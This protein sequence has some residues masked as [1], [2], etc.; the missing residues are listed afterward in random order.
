[1]VITNYF[2]NNFIWFFDNNDS[3]KCISSFYLYNF[4]KKS[5][6]VLGI[7]AYYHDS[8]V[9]LIENGEIKSAVQEER[10]TR[11][12]HDPSF[13]VNA[14][15]YCI[16]EA[17][18]DINQLDYVCFYEKPF[19]KFERLLETYLSFAPKGFSSFRMAIPIWVREK[20]FQKNLLIKELIKIGANDDI[21]KK[22]FSQSII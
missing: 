18:I 3:G 9:T 17:N 21:K 10:F 2:S 5:M 12:K 8:A 1:M 15:R 7:S 14:L 13:P 11:I 22:Y 6:R 20:L 16:N 4:L 19:L